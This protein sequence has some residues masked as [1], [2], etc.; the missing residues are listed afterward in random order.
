[1]A[2]I[3]GTIEASASIELTESDPQIVWCFKWSITRFNFFQQK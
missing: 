3:Q 2:K 1:M